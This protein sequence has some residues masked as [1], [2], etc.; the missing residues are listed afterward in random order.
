[1]VEKTFAA[2]VWGRY[3]LLCSK[4][5]NNILIINSKDYKWLDRSAW[6]V[7][8]VVVWDHNIWSYRITI[9]SQL[10][11]VAV[12]LWLMITPTQVSVMLIINVQ[13]GPPA[14]IIC[15]IWIIS[16]A[17]VWPR[18]LCREPTTI[19]CTTV[20]IWRFDAAAKMCPSPQLNQLSQ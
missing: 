8:F 10:Y 19:L 1:M 9:Y 13:M 6:S 4:G 17:N 16:P 18:N 14:M 5:I 11:A 3:I 15:T 20:A 7:Q 12:L 2:P